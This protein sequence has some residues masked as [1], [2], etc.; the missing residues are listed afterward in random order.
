MLVPV[1]LYRKLSGLAVLG[2]SASPVTAPAA[3][4]VDPY[5][6]GWHFTLTPYVWLPNINGTLDGHVLGPNLGEGP[7]Y[8]PYYLDVGTGS[9]NWT[10]QALLGVGY[11]FDWGD[12]N[13]SIRSLSYDF[14]GKNDADLRMTGLTLGAAFRW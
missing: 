1:P 10:W 2:L 8:M 14:N 4:K 13:L 9:S 5:D 6:G 7:W 11:A 3:D 12:V